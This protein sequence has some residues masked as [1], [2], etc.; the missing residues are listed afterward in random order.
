MEKKNEVK[1][2]SYNISEPIGEVF[3]LIEELTEL[4]KLAQLRF[5][6]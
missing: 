2:F 4:A 6:D 1:N 3:N 5:S